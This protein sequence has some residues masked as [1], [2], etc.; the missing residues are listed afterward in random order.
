MERFVVLPGPE[1][2]ARTGVLVMTAA[3]LDLLAN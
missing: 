1:P 2:S 3:A